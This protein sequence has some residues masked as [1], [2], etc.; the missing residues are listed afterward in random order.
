MHTI[1]TQVNV[2][3]DH[4]LNIDL[5]DDIAEGT[6]QVVIVMNPQTHNKPKKTRLMDKLAQTPLTAEG[7]RSLS[8]DEI[9]D[10]NI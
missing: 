6:Y 3:Q 2:S 7:W 4:I 10:S 1:Q 8:R 9:H 5:P